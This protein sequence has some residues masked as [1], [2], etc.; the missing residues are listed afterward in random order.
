MAQFCLED[1][2]LKKKNI[3]EEF[4]PVKLLGEG[5]FGAVFASV[6]RRQQFEGASGDSVAVKF[7]N[8]LSFEKQ[9]LRKKGLLAK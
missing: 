3:F 7:I 1:L 8:V 5:T 2:G 6:P 9:V 4:R